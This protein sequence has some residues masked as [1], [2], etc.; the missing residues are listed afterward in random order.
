MK[1]QAKTYETAQNFI[2]TVNNEAKEIELLEQLISEKKRKIEK[3]LAKLRAY[4][5]RG[6]VKQ[7]SKYNY[8]IIK[9][10]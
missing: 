6:I 5:K 10:E 8:E 7:N 3:T 1:T 2:D 9:G 4:K